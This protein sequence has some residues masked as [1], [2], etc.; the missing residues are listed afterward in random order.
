MSGKAKKTREAEGKRH[1]KVASSLEVREGEAAD[2]CMWAF[3]QLFV[4]DETLLN[5]KLFE[6]MWK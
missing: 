4:F 3:A 6:Q 5:G 1:Q 2:A